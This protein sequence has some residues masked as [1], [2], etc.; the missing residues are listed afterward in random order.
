[1]LDGSLGCS[2]FFKKLCFFARRSTTRRARVCARLFA[3]AVQ[4]VV[5]RNVRMGHAD[6]AR[7]LRTGVASPAGVRR[8]PPD[9]RLGVAAVQ[10]A[11]GQIHRQ[12]RHLA[13]NRHH[14]SLFPEAQRNLHRK[15]TNQSLHT[16]T[17][18]VLQLLP[19][20]FYLYY[21]R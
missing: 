12:R 6:V 10:G 4:S 21:A 5:G 1:M 3:V 11:D 16:E 9:E 14:Q 8:E 13:A 20:T 2:V 19:H 7:R 15:F 17:V 18:F